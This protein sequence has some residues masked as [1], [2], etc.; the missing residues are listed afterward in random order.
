MRAVS[1]MVESQNKIVCDI[2]SHDNLTNDDSVKKLGEF[3]YDPFSL[4]DDFRT[5]SEANTNY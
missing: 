5:K 1:I 4:G 3:Y 2:C